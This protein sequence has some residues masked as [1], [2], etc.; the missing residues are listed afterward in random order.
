MSIFSEKRWEAFATGKFICSKCWA[1]MVFE[2]KFEENL[3]C[4]KCSYKI[5]LELYGI[6]SEEELN[7]LFPIMEQKEEKQHEKKN[8][9]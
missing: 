5:P 4:P 3:I 9:K 1:E 7:A 6:E 8:K 2:D